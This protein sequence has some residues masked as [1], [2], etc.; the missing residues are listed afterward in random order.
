MAVELAA[1]ENCSVTIFRDSFVM[2]INTDLHG[3]P[4][5]VLSLTREEARALW[6]FLTDALSDVD[7]GAP[8]DV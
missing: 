4:E 8:T 3:E 1:D 7:T 5:S 2:V 6:D